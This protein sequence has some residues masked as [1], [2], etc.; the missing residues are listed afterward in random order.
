MVPLVPSFQPVGV[1]GLPPK[2]PR[3]PTLLGTHISICASAA[4][5]HREAT[6]Q[7]TNPHQCSA[8]RFKAGE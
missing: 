8:R 4:F 7:T 6:E 2:A 3:L 1:C 5:K